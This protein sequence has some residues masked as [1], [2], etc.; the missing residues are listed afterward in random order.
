MPVFRAGYTV[1]RSVAAALGVPFL[2]LSHQEGH[3]WA[4]FLALRE[5][6]EPGEP[7]LAVHVSGG[8][9]EA[10]VG[11]VAGRAAR[12]HSRADG[13]SDGGKIRRPDWRGVGP[14]VSRRRRARAALWTIKAG[15]AQVGPAVQ[16]RRSAFRVP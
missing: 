15:P 11:H 4:A 3:L 12:L 8:T 13:R 6:P 5:I 14:T 10:L 7:F 2:P 9:T 1:A 16:G